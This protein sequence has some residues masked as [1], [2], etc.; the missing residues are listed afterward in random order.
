ML[1]DI[2]R[3]ER[4]PMEFKKTLTEEVFRHVYYE[5]EHDAFDAFWNGWRRD[6]ERP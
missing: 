4:L 3:Y 2:S 1:S 6:L 5:L